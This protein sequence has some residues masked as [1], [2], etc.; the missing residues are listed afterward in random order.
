MPL[1]RR[2]EGWRAALCR[3]RIDLRT[4]RKQRSHVHR[5]P[6]VGRNV[7]SSPPLRIAC[8]DIRCDERALL[9]GVVQRSLP[10][11]RQLPRRQAAGREAHPDRILHLHV[12]R[13]KAARQYS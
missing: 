8:V 11:H 13:V 4:H 3:A 1:P 9:Q 7:Q 5:V 2:V 10:L 6:S 12:H